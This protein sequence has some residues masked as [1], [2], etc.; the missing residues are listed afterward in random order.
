MNHDLTLITFLHKYNI[1]VRRQE[2]RM[3]K[4][5]DFVTLLIEMY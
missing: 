4:I 3:V 1:F 5:D 2:G